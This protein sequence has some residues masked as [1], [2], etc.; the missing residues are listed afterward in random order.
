MMN[1]DGFKTV[2]DRHGHRAGDRILQ[3][4]ADALRGNCRGGDVVARLG[5]DKFVLVTPVCG[6]ELQN[7]IDRI[8]QVVGSLSCE[9]PVCIT[10]GASSYPD[11]GS[12]AETLL[13]KADER[14][15]E[16]KRRKKFLH[17]A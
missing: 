1:L 6:P 9:G 8:S 7:T 11:D 13:E 3:A 17:A 5:D 14:M 4:V 16:A 2:N 12:D 15:G 10:V